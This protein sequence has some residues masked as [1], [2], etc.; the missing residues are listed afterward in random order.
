[1][2]K[3]FMDAPRVHGRRRDQT[4]GHRA[5]PGKGVGGHAG[6]AARGGVLRSPTPHGVPSTTNKSTLRLSKAGVVD[7]RKPEAGAC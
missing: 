7:P 4:T 1:M 2:I 5:R 6:K 3:E